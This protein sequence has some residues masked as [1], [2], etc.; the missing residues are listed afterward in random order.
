VTRAHPDNSFVSGAPGFDTL[1]N[2]PSSAEPILGR[3]HGVRQLLIH[4]M[5][6]P[7]A[8]SAAWATIEALP[9]PS[10]RLLGA[11][12]GEIIVSA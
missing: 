7:D 6:D 3:N 4:A 8:L 5:V 11:A 9:P 1:G 10:R 2:V 12:L